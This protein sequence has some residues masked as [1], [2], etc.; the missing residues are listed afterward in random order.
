MQ[1][2]A[3]RKVRA[4]KVCIAKIPPGHGSSGA[5]SSTQATQEELRA[6]FAVYGPLESISIV[7]R[8]SKLTRERYGFANFYWH[9]DAAN[10]L[11]ALKK[12][13]VILRDGYC[14][15]RVVKGKWA[16]K[17]KLGCK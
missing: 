8:E 7:K 16:Q 4:E 5:F 10:C 14:N 6:A 2:P 3:T 17:S 12:G 15:P 11:A 9:E 13:E 1:T